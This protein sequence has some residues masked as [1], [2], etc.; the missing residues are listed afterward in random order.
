MR[1]NGTGRE[2]DKTVVNCWLFSFLYFLCLACSFL[3]FSGY[4]S[5]GWILRMEGSMS[6]GIHIW[7]FDDSTGALGNDEAM[8]LFCLLYFAT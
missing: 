5:R 2:G 8:S 7:D 4:A 6:R 3:L 1:C